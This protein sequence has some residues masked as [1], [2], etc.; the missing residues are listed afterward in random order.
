[1]NSALWFSNT[2]ASQ[3]FIANRKN[4]DFWSSQAL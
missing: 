3:I 2:I 1:M 4:M